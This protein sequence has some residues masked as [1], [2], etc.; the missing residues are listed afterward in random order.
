M[1]KAVLVVQ[2]MPSD[3][4][5]E[6]EYNDW[7]DNTHLREVCD[8]PGFVSARRYKIA[9]AGP[10]K[11]DPSLPQYLAIYE[12]DTDDVGATIDEMVARSLD[13]RIQMSDAMAM[14]PAPT[15]TLYEAL[16]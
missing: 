8:V 5:R 15:M 2:T 6:Q 7:Y 1:P 13:G 3:P 12:I 10:F 9:D 11:A 14:D 4:S 16:D